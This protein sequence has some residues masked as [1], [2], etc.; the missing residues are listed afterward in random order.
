MVYLV[1]S[2]SS[3]PQLTNSCTGYFD[4]IPPLAP[5]A[6]LNAGTTPASLRTSSRYTEASDHYLRG[7]AHDLEKEDHLLEAAC[8]K[9]RL[10]QWWPG[11]I[12]GAKASVRADADQAGVEMAESAQNMRDMAVAMGVIAPTG[13]ANGYDHVNGYVNGH[14]EVDEQGDILMG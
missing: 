14:G 8:E 9:G 7:L 11:V 13:D 6:V 2:H 12:E 10:D 5:A 3:L 4:E 1:P